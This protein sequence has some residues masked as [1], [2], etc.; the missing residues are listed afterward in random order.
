LGKVIFW[1]VVFFLVLLALRLVS[2]YKARDDAKDSK[3]NDKPSNMRDDKP[4]DDSM[5]KCVECGVFMPK[6]T[7]LM[8]AKGWSCRDANCS[9]RR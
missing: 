9:N 2:V 3:K 7:S 8:K 4:A 6:T 5:V 1:I